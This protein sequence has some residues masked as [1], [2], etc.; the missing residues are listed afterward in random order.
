MKHALAF[1]IF[2]PFYFNGQITISENN[3]PN[4]GENFIY[5]NASTIGI[6]LSLTGANVV[7][8]YS[9]LSSNNYDTTKYTSVTSTPFAYQLFFNNI[10]LYP[11]Y[12]A[13]YSI[14]GND[15]QSPDPANTVTI[16][17]VFDFHK[18]NNSSIEMVGFGANIN[19]IPASI[20]YDTIDQLYP[21][22][23]TFGTTDSTSA[24]Y[25]LDVPNQGTYGQHI[26]RKVEVDGWGEIITPYQTYTQ[27]LRVKTTL[28]QRD[29]LKISQ[30][31]ALPGFAFNRPVETK[32]EWFTN[33]IGVPIFSVTQ[34]EPLQ[35]GALITSNVKYID[36]NTTSIN[37][38]NKYPQLI[39]YPNP[40]L[41]IIEF[42]YPYQNARTI[43]T[44]LTGK[45]VYN[46]AFKSKIDVSELKKGTYSVSVSNGEYTSSTMIQ[47]L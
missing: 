36:V 18:K 44:D 41:A 17:E 47:K 26:Q 23:M 22:P 27:S 21:L 2:I 7:W 20:R 33:G 46:E 31:F 28:Y 4:S 35:G 19:G 30:P 14:K 8:D 24:Y 32:Y 10:F 15:F 3:F 42:S 6:D 16:S 9:N 11:N 38:K 45:I 39:I 12:K 29:T 43:I 40:A 25:L 1:L 5:S 37:E 13:N 34:Q